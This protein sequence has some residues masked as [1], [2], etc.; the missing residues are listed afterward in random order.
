MGSLSS[1]FFLSHQELLWH[2]RS[3]DIFD[4][5]SSL[6]C[7]HGQNLLK[8]GISGASFIKIS[9][10]D[11]QI[12]NHALNIEI[13]Y[14]KNRGIRNDPHSDMAPHAFLQCEFGS[15]NSIVDII[16]N[17]ANNKRKH[18]H[19]FSQIVYYCIN[20]MQKW[21]QCISSAQCRFFR[22]DDNKIV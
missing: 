8:L 6:C 17:S 11:H 2:P 15:M 12:F 7:I 1:G 22:K 16:L 4:K 13:C 14:F 9:H 10:F 20:I 5:E 18:Y 21:F 19:V 3:L